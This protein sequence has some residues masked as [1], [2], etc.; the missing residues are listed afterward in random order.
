M[1]MKFPKKNIYIY[2][3]VEYILYVYIYIYMY[4]CINMIDFD[5]TH[6]LRFVTCAD[7]VFL[8][9]RCSAAMKMRLFSA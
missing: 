7:I 4:I 1:F 6:F 2:T 3:D 9:F 5:C 8:W